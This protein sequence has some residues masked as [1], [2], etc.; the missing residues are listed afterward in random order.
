MEEETQNTVEDNPSTI[1]RT[2][3]Q[4]LSVSYKSVLLT[5]CE[6]RTHPHPHHLRRMQAMTD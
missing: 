1:L 2:A 3:G 5:L 4:A 6:D